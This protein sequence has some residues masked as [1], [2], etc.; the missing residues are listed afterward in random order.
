MVSAAPMAGFTMLVLFSFARMV[1][2]VCI[3]GSFAGFVGVCVALSL[4]TAAFGLWFEAMGGT[5]EATRGY[6]IIAT[7]VMVMLGG[8][9]VP[10]L[11]FP[12]WLRK[13]TVA[14]PTCA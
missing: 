5:V 4:M 13:L 6:S 10:T 11:I 1:F 7:L 8:A 12:A 14:V 2:G 3:L 9:W